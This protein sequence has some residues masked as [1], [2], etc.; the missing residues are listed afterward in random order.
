MSKSLFSAILPHALGLIGQLL[1]LIIPGET[2]KAMMPCSGIDMHS[3]H[4]EPGASQ[5]Y[6]PGMRPRGSFSSATAD[7]TPYNPSLDLIQN[8]PSN[9]VSV[10]A[11]VHENAL[12]TSLE[13]G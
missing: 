5:R 6:S 11:H 9:I 12:G 4:R 7:A 1:D 2:P 8:P 10:P 3:P 13:A